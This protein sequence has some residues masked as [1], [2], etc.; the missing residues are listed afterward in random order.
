VIIASVLL[1]N[2]LNPAV[3]RQFQE[4]ASMENTGITVIKYKEAFEDRQ[5]A[6]RL[7]MYNDHSH[8]EE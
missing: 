8:F 2:K 1:G 7:W 6:W 4:H 3:M 5:F